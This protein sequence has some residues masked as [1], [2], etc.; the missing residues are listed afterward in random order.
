MMCPDMYHYLLT[1]K[2]EKWARLKGLQTE[3]SFKD[4]LATLTETLGEKRRERVASNLHIYKTSP[5][6]KFQ[7]AKS[8]T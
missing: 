6:F 2:K 5:S 1:E 4:I 7:Y 3:K 8:P